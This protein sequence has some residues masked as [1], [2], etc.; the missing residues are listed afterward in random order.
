MLKRLLP[1]ALTLALLAVPLQAAA[2]DYADI[3]YLPSES[4]CGPTA[5]FANSA[6]TSVTVCTPGSSTNRQNIDNILV[7]TR[8]W[9]LRLQS[10]V[11]SPALSLHA[12]VR[13]ERQPFGRVRA[14]RRWVWLG[15]GE[16]RRHA[17][18]G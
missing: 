15:T 18:R 8:S 10:S 14:V 3:G 13:R 1:A 12:A 5:A 16:A 17:D 11:A 4:G 9:G 2:T 6:F 7:D